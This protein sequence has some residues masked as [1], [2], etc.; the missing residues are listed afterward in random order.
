MHVDAVAAACSIVLEAKG[1][2]QPL[3]IAEGDRALPLH[4]AIEHPA[5]LRH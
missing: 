5:G 2:E 3:K 1:K 4:Y